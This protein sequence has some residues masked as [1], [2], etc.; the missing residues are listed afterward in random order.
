VWP[1]KADGRHVVCLA[2]RSPDGQA[3][4]RAPA[5]AVAAW[6]ERTLRL[7]PPGFEAEQLDVEEDLGALLRGEWGR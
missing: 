1:G 6:L 4:L 2:L 5:T 3:L 7:V